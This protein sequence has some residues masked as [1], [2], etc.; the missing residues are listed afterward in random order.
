MAVGKNFTRLCFEPNARFG[1]GLFSRSP[2][3]NLPRAATFGYR[4]AQFDQSSGE[5]RS[6]SGGPVRGSFRDRSVSARNE[7]RGDVS[8]VV[9]DGQVLVEGGVYRLR[10]EADIIEHGAAENSSNQGGP[11][12]RHLLF[13][14]SSQ[15]SIIPEKI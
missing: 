8:L 15:T 1:S 12:V 11:D 13:R 3:F 2:R 5:C 9:V 4:L 6:R 7:C 10:D 14:E